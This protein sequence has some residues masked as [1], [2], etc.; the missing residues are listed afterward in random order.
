M[1]FRFPFCILLVALTV[2]IGTALPA[3]AADTFAC[4]APETLNK[5]IDPAAQLEELSC[6]FKKWDGQEVLHFNVSI[7]NISDQPQRY[8]VNIFLD[9]GKAVGGLIPRKT[10]QGLVEPGQ[11]AGFTY[12]VKGMTAKPDQVDLLIKTMAP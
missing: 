9:N 2:G 10:S 6:F 8:R 7:T 5:Q 11:S 1:T 4:V 12:P 3:A